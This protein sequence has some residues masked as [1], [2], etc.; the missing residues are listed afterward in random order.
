MHC[1]PAVALDADAPFWIPKAA[2]YR[3]FDQADFRCRVVQR[4]V[5]AYLE[6]WFYESDGKRY[7]KL[8]PVSV[9]DGIT[10]FVS[11]RHRTAVLLRHLDRV[12]LSFDFRCIRDSDKQWIDSI[13]AVPIDMGTHFEL[14]DLTIKTA[15][16]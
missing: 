12:P 13:G 9:N 11:G 2:F 1:F 15:L 7:F 4:V 3:H 10:Q 8:P 14:P 16:P 5:D 6:D